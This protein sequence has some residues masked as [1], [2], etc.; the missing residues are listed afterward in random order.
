MATNPFAQ[1]AAHLDRL[2]PAEEL[3]HLFAALEDSATGTS[4]DTFGMELILDGIEARLR[5]HHRSG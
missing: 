1:L 2:A 4:D 3:P 5:S